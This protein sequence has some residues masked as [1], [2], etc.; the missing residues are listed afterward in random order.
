MGF[1]CY[2][3]GRHHGFEGGGFNFFLGPPHILQGPPTFWGGSFQNVR[4]SRKV[5]LHSSVAYNGVVHVTVECGYPIIG[6]HK[7]ENSLLCSV[8]IHYWDTQ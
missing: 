1:I 6:I 2:I 7:E 5:F 4:G 8:D 3:Q